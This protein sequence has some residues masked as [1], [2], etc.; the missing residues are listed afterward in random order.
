M[1]RSE[2]RSEVTG[3]I[4]KIE[5]LAGSQVRAGNP[6]VVVESMKMEVPLVS[7]QDGFVVEIC[8]A[9]GESVQE[10]QLLAILEI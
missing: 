6:V 4:W 1:A 8:V 3:T 9:E 10:G 2:I 7:V 5:V